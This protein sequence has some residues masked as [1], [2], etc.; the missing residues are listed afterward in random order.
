MRTKLQC[1][2]SGIIDDSFINHMTC[3][4]RQIPKKILSS[5]LFSIKIDCNEKLFLCIS[6]LYF[7]NLINVY[8]YVQHYIIVRYFS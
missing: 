3:H 2:V 5:H 7:V 1:L 8:L 4:L 6:N